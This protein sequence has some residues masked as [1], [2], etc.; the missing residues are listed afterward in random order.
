LNGDQPRRSNGG[1]PNAQAVVQL[2]AAILDQATTTFLAEGFA[3]TTIEGIAKSSRV[4]KR[5]IYARWPGKQAL[6]RAIV[7]RLLAN[8]FAEA[9]RDEFESLDLT[10]ALTHLAQQLL[11]VAL[12][13]EAVALHR[14]MVSEAGRFPE[15][16]IMM[17]QVGALEGRRRIIALLERHIARGELPPQD[18][19]FAA[20]QFQH[21]VLTG[22]QRR[23]LGFGQ[24]FNAEEVQTWGR[25]AVELFLRGIQTLPLPLRPI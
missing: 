4:A 10:A 12:K 15:L 9:E 14:L 17:H 3:A 25:R 24:M 20:E 21:L 2:E 22:P 18:T 7:E 11:M 6:F 1:R 13:P 19:G 5:T 8:W 16:P 23:A